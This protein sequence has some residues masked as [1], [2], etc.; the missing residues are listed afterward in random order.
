MSVVPA[1]RRLLF[2]SVLLAG[3]DRS[4]ATAPVELGHVSTG[5]DEWRGIEAADEGVNADPGR[6]PHGRKLHVRSAPA[7]PTPDSAAAQGTRLLALNKVRGLIGPGRAALAERVGTAAQ[8][9]GGVVIG[10]SGWTGSPTIPNLFGVGIAPAERGRVLALVVKKLL[11]ERGGKV[12]IV[13]DPA[14]VSANAAADR[15]ARECRAFATV[16]ELRPSAK[17]PEADVVFFATPTAVALEQRA[18][19]P[20]REMLFGDEESELPALLTGGDGFVVAMPYDLTVTAGPAAA[21]AK[22]YREKFGQEPTTAAALAY[23]AVAVWAE[24]ARRADGYEAPAVRAELIKRDIPF[25][26][27]AGPLV[28]AD[29]HT[30]RRTVHVARIR[31]GALK[32]ESVHEPE[33]PY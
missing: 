6:L 7:G 31:S 10:T 17:A 12:V 25:D 1:M 2:L 18:A 33:P 15:F 20:A 19:F 3:C 5:E 27:L 28:F 26:S 4:A 13:R 16:T 14:A 32:A 21:F 9:E 30:A 8:A 11:A 29:D 22:H 24:A 23:D